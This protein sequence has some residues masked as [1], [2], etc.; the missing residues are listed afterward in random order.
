MKR[1]QVQLHVSVNVDDCA[2]ADEASTRVKLCLPKV[3]INS[4]KNMEVVT[5]AVREVIERRES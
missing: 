5:C 2:D 1:F 4:I 3:H